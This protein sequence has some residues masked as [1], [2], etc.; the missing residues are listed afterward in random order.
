MFTVCLHYKY[1]AATDI[2]IAFPRNLV[3]KLEKEKGN[4]DFPGLL[5][6]MV[7]VPRRDREVRLKHS[8]GDE[9]SK[10]VIYWGVRGAA[11]AK[12][13]VVPPQIQET[14]PDAEGC[15]LHPRAHSPRG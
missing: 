14:S 6:I 13:P 10:G 5:F 12:K 11:Q 4:L 8:V 1:F 3:K 15:Q 2:L 9:K 7:L